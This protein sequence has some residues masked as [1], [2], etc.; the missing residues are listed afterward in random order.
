MIK[1]QINKLYSRYRSGHKFFIS[2]LFKRHKR[3]IIFACVALL[4]VIMLIPPLTYLYFAGDLKDKDSIMNRGKTGLTLLDRE[5]K[6]FFTFYQPKDI[7]YVPFSD[8]PQTLQQAAI[9]AEDRNFY[10]N[11]GFSIRGIA[12]AFFVNILAGRVVEGGSTITQELAKNAFLT[13]KRNYLRKYQELVL[14]SELNRRFSK[15]DILEMYLNSVYFGEGAFGAENAAQSYFGKSAKDL[16]L[17]E[18]AM[19]VGILPA[20][21]AF[22]PLSNDPEIALTKRRNVLQKMVQ[23]KY[24]TQKEADAAANEKLVFNPAKKTDTNTLAPHFAIYVKNQLLK[25]Y[26]EERVIREGFQVQTTLDSKWQAYAENVVAGQVRNLANNNTTNGAAI[27][28][29]PKNGEITVMVGSYDWEDEKFGKANMTLIPRQPGSSF[30]PIIYADALEART[31]T[32]AT[33]L[34]DNPTTFPG[35]YTPKN[36]DLRYRGSVTTRRALSNSLNIPAVEV[37]EKT[38]VTAGLERAEKL[39]ISTLGTDASKYGLSL[40]LGTGEVKLIDLVSAYGVFADKGNYHEPKTVIEIKNKYGKTVNE[41]NG[42][43]S[44]FF[45]PLRKSKSQSVLSSETAFLISSMLSDNSARAEVFGGALTISRPAAVKTGT[46]EE[47]RDALTVGYA[48]SLV[49]GVWVGNND[50]TPMDNIAG[51][52]GAAPIWRSLMENFLTGTAI[53]KFEKPAFVIEQTVCPP[54]KTPYK[55]FFIAG[56]QPDSCEAPSPTPTPVPSSSPT[57]TMTPSPSPTPEPTPTP[58]PSPTPAPAQ[59]PAVIAPTIQFPF[60]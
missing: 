15:Q 59:I 22:S 60:L 49:I 25:E 31:I 17:S 37:M 13:S 32:P 47:Y 57:P 39:G 1:K 51:S 14:A 4:I 52:L 54:G 50:N 33:L 35:N 43:W 16:T 29:N 5:G 11:P 46:T 20:P 56:T 7:E 42:F 21:S 12:R 3:L 45:D 34:N 24:I 19:L 44:F 41:E 48:P 53:E 26:G 2:N 23:E 8:I 30:K 10:T 55:E 38:G 27:A 9:A 58:E 18:S 40:V 36:Y 28:M 6:E